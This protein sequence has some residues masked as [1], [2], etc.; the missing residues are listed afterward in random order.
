MQIAS[1]LRNKLEGITHKF[2]F[3]YL[4]AI[5]EKRSENEAKNLIS[6]R[7][8]FYFISKPVAVF[9]HSNH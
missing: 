1:W 6:S 5:S 9:C 8:L 3:I 7:K 4:T 2:G